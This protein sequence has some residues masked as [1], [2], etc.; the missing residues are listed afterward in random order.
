MRKILASVAAATLATAGVVG[1]SG[2]A[3]AIPDNKVPELWICD[4]VESEIFGAG[5]SAWINGEQYLAVSLE[6]GGIF[7]PEGTPEGEP[8]IPVDPYMKTWGGGPK[9]DTGKLVECTA[10]FTETRPG[11]GTFVGYGIAIAAP[12]H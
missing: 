4:G 11:E 5:R 8:G 10:E 12:L 3:Y 9:V 7:T 6:F 2:I 1:V